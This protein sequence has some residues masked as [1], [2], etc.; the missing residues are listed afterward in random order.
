VFARGAA[1]V[2]PGARGTIMMAEYPRPLKESALGHPL[3]ERRFVPEVVIDAIHLAG[4]RRPGGRGDALSEPGGPWGSPL[5]VKQTVEQR[6]LPPPA[7][8]AQDEQDAVPGRP[9]GGAHSSPS[10]STIPGRERR[11]A[12]VSV[13][14][15]LATKQ[16]LSSISSAR[17]RRPC[18]ASSSRPLLRYSWIMRRTG[19]EVQLTTAVTRL[20]IT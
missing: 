5:S 7:G 11:R 12:R 1:L 19:A 17:I 10:A 13:V 3:L 16:P 20:A 2:H 8:A 14:R 4:T 15:A 6:V 18:V 9:L